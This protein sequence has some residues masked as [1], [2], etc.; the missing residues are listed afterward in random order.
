MEWCTEVPLPVAVVGER[1]TKGNSLLA[2]P[3]GQL[4]AIAGAG[5][6]DAS[7]PLKVL[8]APRSNGLDQRT[9]GFSVARDAVLNPRRNLC[10]NSAT[11]ESF[12]LQ[13]AERRS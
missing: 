13:T 11:D 4:T 7:L 8:P 3:D 9:H 2:F 6:G 10:I 12:V 5:A 1:G